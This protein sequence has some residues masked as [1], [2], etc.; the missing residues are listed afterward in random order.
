VR[1]R[2]VD[3]EG[4]PV[5]S[6]LCMLFDATPKEPVLLASCFT[7]E[8]G[9]FA[10]GPLEGGRLHLVRVYKDGLALRSLELKPDAPLS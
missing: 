8:S 9:H 4:E 6:A 7:D 10:F 3:T 2:V 1:G 5:G